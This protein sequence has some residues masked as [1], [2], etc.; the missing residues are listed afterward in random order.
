[1]TMKRGY[2]LR[3][4]LP[5]R[6]EATD[7]GPVRHPRKNNGPDEFTILARFIRWLD[8]PVLRNGNNLRFFYY[9]SGTDQTV[10]ELAAE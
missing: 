8:E 5:A 2:A 4:I 1:M 7:D 6:Y 3:K 10:R 9:E